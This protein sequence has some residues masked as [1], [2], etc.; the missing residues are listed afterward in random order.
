MPR[1]GRRR[2]CPCCAHAGHAAN[3]A[4]AANCCECRT[5]RLLEGFGEGR[6]LRLIHC[7][8]MSAPMLC[9]PNHALACRA[10]W[11]LLHVAAQHTSR[12]LP[13]TRRSHDAMPIRNR[14]H[15]ILYQYLRARSAPRRDRHGDGVGMA[16]YTARL[17]CPAGSACSAGW[18]LGFASPH[19][20]T[21]SIDPQDSTVRHQQHASRN[22]RFVPIARSLVGIGEM[23]LI[24]IEVPPPKTEHPNRPQRSPANPAPRSLTF[25]LPT[26]S[27]PAAPLPGPGRGLRVTDMCAPHG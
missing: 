12:R 10:S 11:A 23:R 16:R 9:A 27:R 22:R 19:V 18:V 17:R 4:N 20:D 21:A 6:R 1:V 25:Q 14:L 8:P 5:S 24:L 7:N 26:H 3:A 2:R 15:S 13:P